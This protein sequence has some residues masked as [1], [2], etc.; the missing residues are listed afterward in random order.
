MP[1]GIWG[2]M[3]LGM[4]HSDGRMHS[5]LFEC[6][7]DGYRPLQPEI[8]QSKMI[9]VLNSPQINVCYVT[10]PGL[11]SFLYALVLTLVF[12]LLLC[13]WEKKHHWGFIPCDV[14][15][16]RRMLISLSLICHNDGS[17]CFTTLSLYLSLKCDIYFT[18]CFSAY[19]WPELTLG[20]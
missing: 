6:V 5:D 16:W 12:F 13:S 11:N 7:S 8:K 19:G 17:Y 18:E 15:S 10:E 9:T 14:I 20:N 2:T 3:T 1:G 4:I